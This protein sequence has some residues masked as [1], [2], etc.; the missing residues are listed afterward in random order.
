MIAIIHRR[1]F[2]STTLVMII[3]SEQQES[4]CFQLLLIPLLV[5]ISN[6][7]ISMQ[8]RICF[9]PGT[10][11]KG[12][13]YDSSGYARTLSGIASE[14]VKVQL[15][16]IG[17]PDRHN[18]S[19]L[20][21]PRASYGKEISDGVYDGC[22]GAL[23]SGKAD[24]ASHLVPFPVTAVNLT[25]GPALAQ[26]GSHFISSIKGR[27]LHTNPDF[28]GHVSFQSSSLYAITSLALILLIWFSSRMVIDSNRRK[29][30]P[31]YSVAHISWVTLSYMLGN[32]C[33]TKLRVKRML[34]LILI[35]I[36]FI[37]KMQTN[38]VIKTERVVM[39]PAVRLKTMAQ[40]FERKVT[41][42]FADRT[43]YEIFDHSRFSKIMQMMRL[44]KMKGIRNI[45]FDNWRD[46]NA[47]KVLIH[48][49][50]QQKHVIVREFPLRFWRTLCILANKYKIATGN[51]HI[52]FTKLDN[53]PSPLAGIVMS[54]HLAE[55]NTA[56]LRKIVQ[57][58][59]IAAMET[60]VYQGC[61]R[62]LL[63]SRLKKTRMKKNIA[64][65]YARI[66]DPKTKSR[67]FT[68]D[69]ASMRKLI[70]AA[71]ITVTA[72]L[73]CLLIEHQRFRRIRQWN[74]NVVKHSNMMV[75]S[76]QIHRLR[77]KVESSEGVGSEMSVWRLHVTTLALVN[78]TSIKFQKR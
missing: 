73:I 48:G 31:R 21:L 1:L 45:V 29:K 68:P 43:E 24:V 41:F 25:Q 76:R 57:G 39:R 7:Q 23:Q 63:A 62:Q 55:N 66:G 2:I 34:I 18:V 51:R 22:I 6:E 38:L 61:V 56:L 37:N 4:P 50:M 75:T 9:R 52:I 19:L 26:Y 53:S 42:A 5:S 78:A 20:Y 60:K 47:M 77:N 28:M 58:V 69:L 64:Q 27:D 11:L 3:V 74:E 8:I 12:G 32:F 10:A 16:L 44:T 46:K 30:T 14:A 35:M 33:A 40:L 65:C 49:L 54:R 36:A 72:A 67:L 13:N 15:G 71:S 59:R 70:I 17:W